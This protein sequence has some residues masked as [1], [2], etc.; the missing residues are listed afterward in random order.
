MRA[1]TRTGE[2]VPDLSVATAPG[3]TYRVAWVDVPDRDA[4]TIST[5]KQ[6]T[7][8][9]VTRGRKLEGMWWGDGGA[10]FT[11]SFARFTDGSA[12]Q[13][14]VV[15]STDHGDVFVFAR[16]EDPEQ[17][18]FAGPTFSH[19]RRILFANVQSP[20]YTF[21]IQGPWRRQP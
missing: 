14:D 1:F 4:A 11:A 15:G 8:A 12:A 20:G 16:N 3:T 13:H 17:S 7:H 5:R 21:A 19:D 18:E 9:Q 2:H 10:Y 6:F